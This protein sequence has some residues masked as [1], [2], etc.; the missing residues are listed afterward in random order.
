MTQKVS[1]TRKSKKEQHILGLLDDCLRRHFDIDDVDFHRFIEDN[2][3]YLDL[4]PGDIL[5]T[6][7]DLSDE[8][9][10]L[11]SGRLRALITTSNTTQQPIGEIGRGETVGEMAMF[12]GKPRGATIVAIR[13]S[14]VAKVSRK[15]LQEAIARQPDIAIKMT[16][17]VIAR[18]ER[19]Q[20]LTQPPSV[21]V[22]LTILPITKGVDAEDLAT[23]LTAFRT[24]K[25]DNVKTVNRSYIADNLGELSAP[26]IS[27]P[28]GPVSLGLG[29]LETVHDGLFYVADSRDLIWSETAIHHS[30]EVIILADA[31]KSPNLTEL[32]R[33]LIPQDKNTRAR[34][35]LVLV[36]EPDVISPRGTANWL[37]PRQAARHV[38]IRR[39]HE[40]D[41]ERL[42]RILSGRAIGLVLSGGG[43]RGFAHLGTYKALHERG[44]KIDMVGGTSAGAIMG[45]WIALDTPGD[46][47]I[48]AT[49]DV[50]LNSPIG[51]I[52]GDY[53]WL[54]LISLIKGKRA[55][56][57]TR[58]LVETHAGQQ[59]DLE[60]SWKSFFTIA[61]NYSTQEEV[62]LT[63]G[64]FAR[65]M[66][67][68]FSIPGV[69]PPLILDKHMLFD[70][71]IFNNFPV[72]RMRQMGA[73]H[74]I[75]I[76]L[77]SDH[78]RTFEKK[79]VPST[80]RLL[81]DKLRPKS[82]RKYKFPSLANTMLSSL[83]VTSMSR[84]K[85]YRDS[86]DILFKPDVRGVSMLEWKTYDALVEKS[87]HQA[88]K[89]L[90][91]LPD[92]YLA[93]FKA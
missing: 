28:R 48:E 40:G 91:A 67:A 31:S 36:H 54:P 21:A 27:R 71:G 87:Y 85:A 1:G 62:V 50:F 26:D 59:I 82:K 84:Q 24:Q 70:G 81:L 42:S 20:A 89:K 69:M 55:W 41:L 65:N 74:V 34:V 46:K 78:V 18:Y 93:A 53:N 75:G 83:V 45:S 64:D 72:D 14:V 90:N 63:R 10:F 57:T 4:T 49:R 76:D 37:A 38:H 16:R 61:S 8:V 77:M 73:G 11:L 9:Y 92:D 52:S 29:D 13:D 66:I 12:T 33:A 47:I 80:F 15:V 25:G 68:S 5:L 88:L 7:G 60:D 86:V 17:Q 22:S 35:T 58:K 39:G 19:M 3:D 32:E 51:N 56:K 79:E 6:Q 30:D 23:R 44:V 43:A 2:S